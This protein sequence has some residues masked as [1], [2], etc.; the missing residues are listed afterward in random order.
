MTRFLTDGAV[1]PNA[2]ELYFLPLGGAGEIGMNLYLYG[3]GP[4]HKRRW[5]IVDL[6]VKFGDERDPGIDVVLPDIRFLKASRGYLSR[7][8]YFQ[9]EISSKLPYTAILEINRSSDS[10][11]T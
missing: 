11:T 6:G 2:D 3:H 8:L 9:L 1:A 10:L 5:L 4:A 7:Q